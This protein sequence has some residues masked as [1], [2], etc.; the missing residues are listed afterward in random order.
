MTRAGQALVAAA[1][2]VP[3]I[4]RPAGA[5]GAMDAARPA[6]APAAKAHG[7]E[8]ARLPRGLL[9]GQTPGGVA[10]LVSARPGRADPRSGAAIPALPAD[11]AAALPGIGAG[12][13]GSQDGPPAAQ[14]AARVQ[15]AAG[16]DVDPGLG[17]GTAGE[18][19]SFMSG[20]VAGRLLLPPAPRPPAGLVLLLHDSLSPDLR[21]RL[22]E[23]QLLG[24]GIAVLDVLRGD[25]DPEALTRAL[26]ALPA[27]AGVA[28]VPVGVLGFGAG[29]RLA[30]RLGPGIAAR[31]LLYPGCAGLAPAGPA[32]TGPLLLVHGDVDA[33]NPRGACS[34]AA[35]RLSQP[36]RVVRH[37]VY[38]G[39]GYGWDYPAYGLEQ[40]V[41]LP[42][43]EGAGR[44]PA[45]PWP[46]LAA[47]SAAQVAGFFATVLA[48]GAR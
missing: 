1:L 12:A 9:P 11:A 31:A 23:D 28:G 19:R 2:A 33:S 36:G 15:D 44:I 13:H 45:A 18:V 32:A 37:R 29:A 22:Y 5:A 35:A 26:E 43:P 24:A 21:G 25:D 48:A 8:A 27:E 7:G 41:L 38:P 14:A 3:L 4:M 16:L 30:L 20:P 34:D 40:H 39:A 42:P 47:M 46:E 6:L 17:S 10:A